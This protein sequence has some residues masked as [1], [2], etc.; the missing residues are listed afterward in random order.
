MR[1][2]VKQ[3]TRVITDHASGICLGGEIVRS[4]EGLVLGRLDFRRLKLI[5]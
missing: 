2:G 5:A 3:P 1:Y 4:C